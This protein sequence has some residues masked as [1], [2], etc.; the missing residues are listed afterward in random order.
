M[1][2]TF[3]NRLIILNVVT[4]GLILILTL[5][6]LIYG[7]DRLGAHSLG[8]YAF[9]AAAVAAGVIATFVGSALLGRRAARPLERVTA[10]AES[11]DASH[12][13]E[14]LPEMSM[15]DHI[16]RLAAV[17]NRMLSRLEASFE[18][19]RSF[20]DRAAHELRTPLTILK[21]ETQVALGRRRTPE[22]YEAILRSNLEEIEKMALTIDNLLLLAR[23]EGGGADLS[24][25]SARL[26]TIAANVAHDLSPLAAEKGIDLRLDAA[27]PL[28]V[29]GEPLALERL[30]FNLVENA[31]YYT[32]QGGEVN[33]SVEG[34]GERTN[35]TVRD[36]G[37]GIAPEEIPQL[38][39]R[40]FRS[41]A[42]RRM[43]PEG[44]G[45]GLP[46]VAAIARLHGA[47]IDVTSAPGAGTK[48]VIS[49]Q[50]DR[51]TASGD[52]EGW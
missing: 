48:F 50:A 37:V 12:L 34:E 39:N 29:R 21:G 44:S 51:R 7:I 33:V 18:A 52:G 35:L 31:I 46:V 4:L 20:T 9:A 28:Y 43:R 26:D 8:F 17:F 38:Y 6:A 14:R 2:L 40:F 45:I 11:I 19:Q 10:A 23:Y 1:K 3:Q 22:E 42:A 16:G 47:E 30:V 24:C 15:H 32:P 5:A 27:E 25:Q 36:T 13:R 49:F 41:Q